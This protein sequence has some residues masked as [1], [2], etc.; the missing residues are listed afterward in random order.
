MPDGM[1]LRTGVHEP[2]EAAANEILRAKLSSITKHSEKS[3]ILTPW[4]E[5]SRKSREVYVPSGTPDA[6]VRRGN[7]HRRW[8]SGSDHLNSVDG[9]PSLRKSRGHGSNVWDNE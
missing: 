7:F 5:Q 2:I 1:P 6:A 3:D 8:N 4:K 9:V